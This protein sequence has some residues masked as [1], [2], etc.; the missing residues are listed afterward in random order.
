MEAPAKSGRPEGHQDP[1][2]AE[3]ATPSRAPDTARC[4]VSLTASTKPLQGLNHV[5]RFR[6]VARLERTIASESEDRFAGYVEALSTALGHV[7]RRGPFK[8]YCFGLLMPVRAQKRRPAPPRGSW[9]NCSPALVLAALRRSRELVSRAPDERDTGWFL[10]SMSVMVRWRPGSSTTLN[11]RRG[12][13]FGRRPPTILWAP[14]ASGTIFRSPVLVE[15]QA[16]ASLPIACRLYLPEGWA[17]SRSSQRGR[18]Y[19][20]AL[21]TKPDIALDQSGL[22]CSVL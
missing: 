18:V 7:D 2:R 5:V 21:H 13:T 16:C 4:P 9:A 8:D 19:D 10:P 12:K 14:R 15:R 22:P 20:V 3:T 1:A 6:S 17:R 11:F